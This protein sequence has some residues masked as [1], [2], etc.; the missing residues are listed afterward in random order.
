MLGRVT[1]KNGLA[2]DVKKQDKQ[3]FGTEGRRYSNIK[4]QKKYTEAMNEYSQIRKVSKLNKKNIIEKL[5]Y[6]PRHPYGY[7]NSKVSY[8]E[9][10]NRLNLQGSIYEDSQSMAKEMKNSFY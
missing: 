4:L 8:G 10:I 6:K 5:K 1:R 2:H 3:S 9:E 7:I